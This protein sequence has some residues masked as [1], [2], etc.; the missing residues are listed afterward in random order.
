[1]Y[2]S[3]RG[4]NQVLF[5]AGDWWAWPPHQRLH[6]VSS[7]SIKAS[8]SPRTGFVCSLAAFRLAGL[9]AFSLLHRGGRTL[10]T[11][12]TGGN[13]LKPSRPSVPPPDP[14]TAPSAPFTSV[15]K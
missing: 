6:L 12:N 13:L 14:E 7:P 1:M 11:G 10:V 5:F 9:Q 15:N 2:T 8:Q 3:C 4:L